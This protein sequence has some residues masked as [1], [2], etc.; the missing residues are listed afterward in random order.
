MDIIVTTPKSQMQNAAREAED[1]KRAGGGMYFRRFGTRPNVERGDR[2]FYVEDGYVRGFAVVEE[3]RRDDEMI[4][5]TTGAVWPAGWYVFMPAESW[6]W[7]RPIPMKGFQNYRFA[8]A[9]GHNPNVIEE[10]GLVAWIEVVGG[11]LDPKP[12]PG[13]LSALVANAAVDAGTERRAPM[14]AIPTDATVVDRETGEA[15]DDPALAARMRLAL[16]KQI[17]IDEAAQ[18]VSAKRDALDVA[19]ESLADAQ[20]TLQSLRSEL[21]DILAGQQLMF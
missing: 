19:K 12:E 3:V 14:R 18:A 20:A 4:C 16:G 5:E 6:K 7:I 13:E 1:V 21:A 2:L 11:W 8:R 10:A 15:L 9:E 17:E